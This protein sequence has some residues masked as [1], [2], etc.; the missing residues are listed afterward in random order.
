MDNNF[1]K[2][3]NVPEGKIDVLLDT[4]AYNEV[5]D[6]Y[7]ITYMLLSPEKINPVAICAAPFFNNKSTDARD[8]MIKSYNEIFNILT[9]LDRKDMFDSV[10]KGSED[11]LKDENTPIVSDAAKKMIEEAKKHSPDSPLYVVA[12]GAITNVASAILMDKDT[13]VNNTVIVWLGGHATHFHDTREFNMFQDV[14]A[15]RV[16]FA[17]GAPLIQLPCFGVVSALTT[18]EGE[19]NAWIGGTSKLADYLIRM[20]K[21]K[22]ESYAKGKAWSRCIWDVSAIAWL[23]NDNGRFMLEKTIPALIPQYDH[24]Y[25]TDPRRHPQKYVYHVHRDEIFT[26][27]FEKIRKFGKEHNQ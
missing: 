26:D 5:D 12:I 2:K 18:T 21:E 16:V 23:L 27:L 8:G 11:Y 3:L 20:T 4:D 1:Y 25:S 7:A 13:I 9:L 22:A 17:S 19:L 14:A 10:Y 24:H 6:Q 15:A